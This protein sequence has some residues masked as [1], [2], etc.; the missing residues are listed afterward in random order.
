MQMRKSYQFRDLTQ[1]IELAKNEEKVTKK[2]RDLLN[3]TSKAFDMPLQI[4]RVQY[5]FKKT[6]QAKPTSQ[7]DEEQKKF[8]F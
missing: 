8:S 1:S 3:K 5:G 7:F 6:N 2:A 4:P